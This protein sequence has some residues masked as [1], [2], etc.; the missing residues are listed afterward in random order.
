M[1]GYFEKGE[2][3]AVQRSRAVNEIRFLT[4]DEAWGK[5]VQRF[6]GSEEEILA[7][8]MIQM[9]QDRYGEVGVWFSPSNKIRHHGEWTVRV[10]YESWKSPQLRVAFAKA[11]LWHLWWMEWP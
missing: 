2:S 1:I 3:Q 7:K 10:H 9:A 5:V 11:W 4:G 6:S 8:L